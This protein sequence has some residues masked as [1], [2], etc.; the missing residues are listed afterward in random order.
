MS[1]LFGE[2]TAEEDRGAGGAGGGAWDLPR[3]VGKWVLKS[4]RGE[5]GGGWAEA[6][7]NVMGPYRH[8][9]SVGLKGSDM[10]EGSRLESMPPAPAPPELLTGGSWM[11]GSSFI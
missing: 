7:E 8:S 10:P 4:S 3:V 6:G 9:R 2:R 1:Q 11:L 5:A